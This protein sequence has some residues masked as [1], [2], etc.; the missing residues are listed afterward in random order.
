M[1][2]TRI[3]NPEEQDLCYCFVFDL[4]FPQSKCECG[5]WYYETTSL[6]EKIIKNILKQ[7]FDIPNAKFRITVELDAQPFDVR[8]T[9]LASVHACLCHDWTFAPVPEKISK[10]FPKE[11]KD[12]QYVYAHVD[13]ISESCCVIL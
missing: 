13:L 5:Y 6:D 8:Q 10:N 3:A 11:T 7:Y 4:K 2:D 9:D 1:C 12:R